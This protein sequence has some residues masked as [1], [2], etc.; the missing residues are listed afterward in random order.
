MSFEKPTGEEL[1]EAERLKALCDKPVDLTDPDCP[2]ADFTDREWRRGLPNFWGNRE[3][4]CT[5]N[6]ERQ[7]DGIQLR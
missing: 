7:S 2:P 4:L 5:A 1:R 6:E 3:F